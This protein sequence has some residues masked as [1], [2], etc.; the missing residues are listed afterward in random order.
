MPE[1]VLCLQGPARVGK[2]TIGNHLLD[3]LGVERLH[4][5]SDYW[6]GLTEFLRRR[7]VP[8]GDEEACTKAA[9]KAKFDSDGQK[10]W[11]DQEDVTSGLR[12]SV[13]DTYV[14]VVAGYQ[15]VR[16]I[17]V[18]YMHD[19]I[20][21]RPAIIS[22]RFLRELFPDARCVL[23]VV[24]SDDETARLEQAA[25]QRSV[26]QVRQDLERRDFLDIHRATPP[27]L[28][29]RNH[30]DA[31]NALASGV[32]NDYIELDVTGMSKEQQAAAALKLVLGHGF[33]L[34]QAP[35]WATVIAG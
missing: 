25:K 10:V 6:R 2:N 35:S 7:N 21:A 32:Q 31:A 26:E 15:S 18:D 27:T 12:S 20:Q 8:F 19:W 34:V 9:A 28:G 11:F 16:R 5:T 22:G 30:L 17:F 4:D 33:K 23:Q 3:P 14:S 24:R 1:E 29:Y 13:T